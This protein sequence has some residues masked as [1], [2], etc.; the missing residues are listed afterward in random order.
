M[1][2]KLLMLRATGLLAL[3]T[4]V[5]GLRE[6]RAQSVIAGV[7]NTDVTAPNRLMI[8]HESQL[9]LHTY[10]KPYW[11][12]FTFSTFGI[13]HNLELAATLYGL[14]NPGSGNVSVA[15]GYK[16]RIPLTKESPWEPVIAF[17]QMI[18]LSL[19][20]SGFGF[21]TYG[22]S[23]VRIPEL[24]TRF[25]VGLSYGSRQIFGLTSL[26]VLGG[27]EQPITKSF[28]LIADYI[29][30]GSDLGALVPAIQWNPTHAFT[31]ICG[32]KIPNTER[33]GPLSGLLELTYE[34][35]FSRRKH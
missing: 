23:S 2:L 8:A 13:G 4:S 27:V 22:V 32:V 18:P 14:S 24:R 3:A 16:H 7:P 31:V 25:T 12:S 35:D 17:G 5:P 10:P 21:W 29:S 34:F 15:A 11:N 1:R 30:G 9:N 33:A 6:A 26:N 20:G 19:S 28:S